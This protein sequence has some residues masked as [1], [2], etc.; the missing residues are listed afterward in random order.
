MR[1]AI[2]L[3]S[4]FDQCPTPWQNMITHMQADSWLDVPVPVINQELTKFDAVYV[5]NHVLFDSD[6]GR[7][8]WTLKW[9]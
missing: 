8:L 4:Q 9:A 3:S 1:S 5:D 6:A 2:E 7:V